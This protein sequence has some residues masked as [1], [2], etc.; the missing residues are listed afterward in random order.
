M[1]VLCILCVGTCGFSQVGTDVSASIFTGAQCLASRLSVFLVVSVNVATVVAVVNRGASAAARRV[2]ETHVHKVFGLD[3]EVRA[4][5]LNMFTGIV[6]GKQVHV[7]NPPDFDEPF[8]FCIRHFDCALNVWRLLRSRGVEVEIY[9]LQILGVDVIVEFENSRG[10]GCTNVMALLDH[11]LEQ[12][13]ETPKQKNGCSIIRKVEFSGVCARTAGCERQCA[14]GD[15][16]FDDC[17]AECRSRALTDV[18]RAVFKFLLEGIIV[19]VVGKPR[20]GGFGDL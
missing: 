20:L 14:L 16:F 9:A 7:R 18:M 5:S 10:W 15:H 11:L 8:I 3:V 1:V 6:Q 12:P 4:V 13:Y 19:E 2:L 17:M